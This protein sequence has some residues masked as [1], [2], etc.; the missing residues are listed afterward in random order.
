MKGLQELLLCNSLKPTI[1]INGK[2]LFYLAE[3]D[4]ARFIGCAGAEISGDAAL[5]RSTAVLASYR[6]KGIAKRLVDT[7]L[8]ALKEEGIQ[9]LYL[10][11]R[12]TGDFWERLGFTPCRVHEVIGHLPDAPQVVAY[13]RDNSIWSD[14]AW[15]RSM[16]D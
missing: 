4:G 9:N 16:G 12:S 5:I 8:Q 13:L 10:F 1:V 15:C 14:V 7:L 11:S 3:A 6:G 2:S